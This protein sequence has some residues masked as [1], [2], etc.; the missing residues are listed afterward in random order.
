MAGSP[1]LLIFEDFRC[2]TLCG[3]ALSIVAAGVEQSGLR[4][5]RDVRLL[6]IGLNPREGPRDAQAFR[7]AHLADA[8]QLARTSSFLTGD[9]GAI[10]R[11]AG[12]M[13]YGYAYDAATDQF[14]HPVA[15]FVL[16]RD[17]RVSRVLPETALL[18][19][20]LRAAIADADRDRVGDLVDRL[21]VLC[22]D[23]LP[24]TGRYDAGVQIG[25]RI[26]AIATLGVMAAGLATLIRRRRTA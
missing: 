5:G 23:L 19:P 1:G 3:P 17:G 11:A 12:A 7:A 9:A 24:L 13:G 26:A 8:P 6:A 2:R 16:A 25:L 21:A 14:T 20:D 22:H 18:G 15:A 10:R 4:P